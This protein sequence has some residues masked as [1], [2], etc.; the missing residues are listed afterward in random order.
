VI[1]FDNNLHLS[2]TADV[3]VTSVRSRDRIASSYQP[4]QQIS[5][6]DLEMDVELIMGK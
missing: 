1:T 4:E 6:K 3:P 5:V 2:E